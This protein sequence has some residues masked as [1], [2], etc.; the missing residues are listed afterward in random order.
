MEFKCA[1]NDTS[2]VD[3]VPCRGLIFLGEP[4][5]HGTRDQRYYWDLQL[6]LPDFRPGGR[7]TVKYTG[8]NI[9]G[10]QLS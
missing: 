4:D 7:V 3:G 1:E 10:Y 6:P 8:R 5:K 9:I 2:L